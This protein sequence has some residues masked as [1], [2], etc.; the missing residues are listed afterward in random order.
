MKRGGPDLGD[1]AERA[2]RAESMEDLSRV[3]IYF[4][5]TYLVHGDADG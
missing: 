2:E 5:G 3:G 1:K 4:I